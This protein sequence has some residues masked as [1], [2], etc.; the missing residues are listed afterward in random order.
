VVHS[1]ENDYIT[2]RKSTGILPE[3]NIPKMIV[4]D[5]LNIDDSILG[6]S[7]MSKEGN[8]LSSN[9]TD[10]LAKKFEVDR[11]DNTYGL[12]ATIILGLVERS[13]KVFGP[14][15]AVIT[16][17]KGSILMLIPIKSRAIMVGLVLQRA[18]NVEYISSKIVELLEAQHD[19]VDFY[20]V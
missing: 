19:Y 4:E 2:Q 10:V 16:L 6:V 12:W 14:V 17:H 9:G 8:V 1:N 5:I 3:S 15:D 20:G 18:T 11:Y 7:I 13:S